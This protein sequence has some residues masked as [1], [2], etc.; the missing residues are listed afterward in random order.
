MKATLGIGRVRVLALCSAGV[1]LALLGGLIPAA[2]DDVSYQ[3]PASRAV[4]VVAGTAHTC[5]LTDDGAVRCWG[6]NQDGQINVPTNLGIATDL[7]VGWYHTCALT[8][9]SKVTCWGW[10]G[11][12][13]LDVPARVQTPQSVHA[14]YATSCALNADA[15]LQCWGAVLN[16]NEPGYKPWQS[17]GS[18]IIAASVSANHGC[19]L[20]EGGA[21]NCWGSNSSGESNVPTEL[22]AA[23]AVSVGAAHSCA[24]LEDGTVRCW[25]GNTYGQTSVPADLGDVTLLSAG[26]RH[27]CVV[28]ASAVRCWG[29]NDYGQSTVPSGLDDVVSLSAGGLH[30][31][32]ATAS[33]AVS[34]WGSVTFKDGSAASAV[35]ADFIPW[36]SDFPEDTNPAPAGALQV[37]RKSTR[38]NSSHE[39]I[40]RMPSSA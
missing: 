37:D 4:K 16:R 19:A 2:A 23:S 14:G 9:S 26:G 24:L 12:R 25:G 3:D 28:A 18:S 35:P 29:A 7:A 30:T 33:G 21:I 8:D 17:S 13:Q 31:C 11:L 20:V 39:W 15:V 1:A 38:L 6:Y 5:V 36:P 27:T 34:C 10:N 40:S 22:G 32:A